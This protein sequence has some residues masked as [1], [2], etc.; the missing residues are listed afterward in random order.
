MNARVYDQW[1]LRSLYSTYWF[2]ISIMTVFIRSFC[3][4]LLLVLLG[5]ARTDNSFYY[6]KA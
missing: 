6:S 2:E 5:C 3:T 1:L 4:L